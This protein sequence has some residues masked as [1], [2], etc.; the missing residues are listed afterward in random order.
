[1][2]QVTL[3]GCRD[4]TWQEGA[5]LRPLWQTGEVLPKGQEPPPC[6][7]DTRGIC[8]CRNEV[9]AMGLYWGYLLLTIGEETEEFCAES[10]GF[11]GQGP[12]LTPQWCH[13]MTLFICACHRYL[14]SPLLRA[15]VW[16][17]RGEGGGSAPTPTKVLTVM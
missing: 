16:G 3:T 17:H 6:P 4:A 5:G 9:K 1:M 13:S 11:R 8:P 14:S 7:P 10:T 12:N 15:I 2:T